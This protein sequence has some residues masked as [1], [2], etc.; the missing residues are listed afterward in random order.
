[1]VD[2]GVKGHYRRLKGITLGDLNIQLKVPALI[3]RILGP[4]ESTFKPTDISFIRHHQIKAHVL[5]QQTRFYLSGQALFVC[6]WHCFTGG[7]EGM[8]KKRRRR[9]RKKACRL[10]GKKKPQRNM[11]KIVNKKDVGCFEKGGEKEKGT[12]LFFIPHHPAL[13]NNKA[14]RRAWD[15]PSP[16]SLYLSQCFLLW[17][18]EERLCLVYHYC[19]PPP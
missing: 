8:E 2:G 18:G 19:A 12:S 9:R 15:I 11:S 10:G 7:G 14:S 6:L 13:P 4:L 5:I 16:L 3:A 1:M 17:R